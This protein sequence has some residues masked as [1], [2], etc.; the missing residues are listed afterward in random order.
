MNN[1]GYISRVNHLYAV[2]SPSISRSRTTYIP[3]ANHIYAVREPSICGVSTIYIPFKHRL[4]ERNCLLEEN[5][6]NTKYVNGAII[7]QNVAFIPINVTFKPEKARFMYF[8]TH[9]IAQHSIA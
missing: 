8:G 1:V 7:P 4:Y 3:F 9:S 6:G 2:F 5:P